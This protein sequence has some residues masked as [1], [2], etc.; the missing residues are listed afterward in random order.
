MLWRWVGKCLAPGRRC[1]L[2]TYCHLYPQVCAWENLELAYRRARKGKRAR[3]PAAVFE[4]DRER[5]L[6]ELQ[7]E[8]LQKTYRPGPYHSFLI[9]EPKRRLI[10]AAPF[11][12]RVVHHALCNIIETIFERRFIYDS[13]ANRIGKGT[14]RAL[15][16]CTAFARRYR[17][18]LLCDV[19]QFFP[20]IDHAILRRILARYLAD[21]DT[22]WLVD[23]ILKSGV[24]VLSEEY[25][26]VCRREGTVTAAA[27]GENP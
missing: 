15:D 13:Y 22:M 20:S 14:H 23:R 8:L 11:R 4:F 2:K 10:S 25:R 16:R 19:R 26:M 9:H 1:S 6:T 12:D 3:K 24:G 27:A 18:V 17:Y 5:N 21:P 7:E